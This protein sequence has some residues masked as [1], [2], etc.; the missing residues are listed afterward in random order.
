[1]KTLKHKP[2]YIHLLNPLNLSTCQQYLRLTLLLWNHIIWLIR[3]HSNLSII[4]GSDSPK[5]WDM[6]DFVKRCSI[7]F[8]QHHGCD[9]MEHL[10]HQLKFWFPW[11]CFFYVPSSYIL[12]L[13]YLFINWNHNINALPVDLIIDFFGIRFFGFKRILVIRAYKRIGNTWTK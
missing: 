3:Y 9:L 7:S 1:M 12:H 11:C 4:P 8:H 6:I 5:H 13:T 10:V 2:C